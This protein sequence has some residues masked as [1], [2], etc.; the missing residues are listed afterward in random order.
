VP[1]RLPEDAASKGAHAPHASSH[2]THNSTT[3]RLA[4]KTVME[5][6]PRGFL[7]N[8]ETAIPS[9]TD[10]GFEGWPAEDSTAA[11][12]QPSQGQHGHAHTKPSLEHEF[13]MSY[14][15]FEA[16]QEAA[17]TRDPIEGEHRALG[18]NRMGPSPA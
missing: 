10:Q 18:P 14:V 9:P 5:Y 13:E 4:P 7:T 12:D 17:S 8:E 1:F 11:S 6:P 16:R 15:V 2:V 3:P